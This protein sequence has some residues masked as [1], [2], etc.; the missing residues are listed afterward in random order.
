MKIKLFTLFLMVSLGM[1]T[2]SLR[3]MDSKKVI[4]WDRRYD[5]FEQ[6]AATAETGR[7]DRRWQR[8]RN[9]QEDD[10]IGN[11]T[12]TGS[13]YPNTSYYN[14]S[15]HSSG[16]STFFLIKDYLKWGLSGGL[17]ATAVGFVGYEVYKHGWDYQ[18]YR[19]LKIVGGLYCG[20]LSL[21]AY[22]FF[23]D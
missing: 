1:G 11:R 5:A 8:V 4:D 6:G 22:K 10:L 9:Q 12:S 15:N 19:K 7:P 23:N 2:V 17:L 21:L 16:K 18:S 20:A 14:P 13:Q 3:A